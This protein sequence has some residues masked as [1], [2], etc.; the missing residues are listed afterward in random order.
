MWSIKHCTLPLKLS[1]KTIPVYYFSCIMHCS[2]QSSPQIKL[3]WTLCFTFRANSLSE[4]IW[5]QR[6]NVANYY[7]QTTGVYHNTKTLKSM[8]IKKC[9]KKHDIVLLCNNWPLNLTKVRT[10]KI[11]MSYCGL[12]E[13][14]FTLISHNPNLPEWWLWWQT[15]WSNGVCVYIRPNS[16]WGANETANGLLG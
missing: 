12:H 15:W 8:Q 9:A 4:S 11:R 5:R 6:H 14:C 16:H 2:Y 10:G 7:V 13:E 3:L 1:F